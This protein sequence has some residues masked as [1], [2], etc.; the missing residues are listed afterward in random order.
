MA[1]KSNFYE[2]DWKKLIVDEFVDHDNGGFCYS[3][4]CPRDS[5]SK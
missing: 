3:V 5:H 4:M 1:L 2:D